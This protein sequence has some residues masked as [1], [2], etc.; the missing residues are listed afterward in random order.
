MKQLSE[1]IIHI[2][3]FYIMLIIIISLVILVLSLKKKLV[4][5][6]DKIQA[7]EC[8]KRNIAVLTNK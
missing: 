4:D 7:L 5:M 6:S 8:Y 3:V 1:G 2:V